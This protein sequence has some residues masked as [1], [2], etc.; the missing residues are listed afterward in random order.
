[1]TRAEVHAVIAV[2]RR[3]LPGLAPEGLDDPVATAEAVD[4]LKAL[5]ALL[6]R[7]LRA[8]I[9]REVELDPGVLMERLAS[10]TRAGSKTA[11]RLFLGLSIPE[12]E[13]N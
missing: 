1:M 13:R 11:G 10:E 5:L 9:E 8:S 12:G 3:K 4:V 6:P 7:E 2:L